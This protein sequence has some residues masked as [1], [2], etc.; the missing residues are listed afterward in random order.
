MAAS[1]STP[2]TVAVATP[3]SAPRPAAAN[4]HA[5][6]PSRGPQPPMLVGT[7]IAT[8]IRIASGRNWQDGGGHSHGV[9]G[10]EQRGQVAGDHH[11]GREHD[12]RP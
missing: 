6:M 4:A 10:Q 11:H 3:G 5:A 8:S 12:A 9:R 1:A 7:A 2:Y